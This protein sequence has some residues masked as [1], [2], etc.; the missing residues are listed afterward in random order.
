MLELEEIHQRAPGDGMEDNTAT[1]SAGAVA[2]AQNFRPG[3][4]FGLASGFQD[5]RVIRLQAK[6][7]F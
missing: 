1:S 5:P 4:R 2:A 7:S 6:F 3:A